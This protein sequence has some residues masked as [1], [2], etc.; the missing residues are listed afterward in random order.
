MV[1]QFACSKAGF[2]LF[3]LDPELATTDPATAQQALEAALKLTK[4][5]IF[6][7]QEAGSDV[8][9]VRLAAGVIPEVDIFDYSC[10]MP[11]VTPRFPDLRFCIQTGFDQD[12]KYGWLLLRH[13]LVPSGNLDEFVPTGS[14]SASTPLAGELILN[15]KK[16]PT[17]I[18]KAL[19]NEQVM[20][21]S[22]WPTYTK[23]LKKEFHVV[24]GVGVIF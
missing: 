20:K 7:S 1:L 23:I 3:T 22:A 13:M 16:V 18:G 17:K 4:A 12:D 21:G 24:E 2:V 19:T 9:Y 5:N 11:F 6:V 15:E 10:G 14:V 8:N